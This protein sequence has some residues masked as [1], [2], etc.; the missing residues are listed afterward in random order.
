MKT[1]V[2]TICAKNYLAQARVLMDSVGRYVPEATRM[3]V[4]SDRIDG[5]FDPS[6]ESFAVLKA[7]SLPID[8][9]NAM[10]F[11]YDIMELATAIKPS[12]FRHML[13]AQ[14]FQ[15]VVYLDPDLLMFRALQSVTAALDSGATG[16]MT[17]HSLQPLP[18]GRQ[19]GNATLQQAGCHNLGFLALTAAPECLAGLRWWET[20]LRQHCRRDRTP[21]GEFVDQKWMDFWPLLCPGTH[22][23]R[24]PGL[25]VAYWN[26]D[27]RPL[28]RVGDTW[29]AGPAPLAFMH[30]SG[31]R[32]GPPLIPSVHRRELDEVALG[33]GIALFRDYACLLK[34]ADLSTTAS[35]PYAY[36][37]FHD[38]RPITFAIRQFYRDVLEPCDDDPF[39][40]NSEL[41]NQLDTSKNL[42]G[43]CKVT[44]LMTYL[45]R[46][47][48][49]LGRHFPLDSAAGRFAFQQW[50]AS[51]AGN[52]FML[53]RWLTEAT[54]S[55]VGTSRRVRALT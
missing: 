12:V 5:C 30:F 2:F 31:I 43:D 8:D 25:N 29:Y 53:P 49:V 51:E 39:A 3:V 41:Y 21:S 22:V 28:R 37:H 23:L 11:R 16:A 20:R 1:A 38:G 24:D 34:E 50:F 42:A 10:S 15:R 9:F 46:Q 14:G 19:I 26:L 6:A 13:E 17:P 52:Y 47:H 4:L 48:P 35:W 55:A 45:A 32:I 54:Q 33:E 40:A 27:E 7:D 36:D 44:R 18:P